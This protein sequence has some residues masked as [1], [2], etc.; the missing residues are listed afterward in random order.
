MWVISVTHIF[1]VL[2]KM[3]L[4]VVT[5]S[6]PLLEAATTLHAFTYK[7]FPCCFLCV[8]LRPLLLLVSVF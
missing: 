6:T 8:L 7:Y 3:A 1:H 5:V 4:S 2:V